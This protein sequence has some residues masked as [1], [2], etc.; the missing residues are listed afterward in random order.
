HVWQQDNKR[1]TEAQ[2]RAPRSHASRRRP[3]TGIEPLE[4]RT[5]LVANFAQVPHTL[6]TILTD[7]NSALNQNVWGA[8]PNLPILGSALHTSTPPSDLQFLTNTV[9]SKLDAQFKLAT[10]KTP[11]DVEQDFKS[12]L[13]SVVNS[14][15]IDASNP[16]NVKFKVTLIQLPEVLLS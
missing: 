16:D 4:D 7:L 3:Q 9:Q 2:S 5:L 1:V 15:Q 12:A 10:P 8:S 6:D 11:Q 13:G 14:F